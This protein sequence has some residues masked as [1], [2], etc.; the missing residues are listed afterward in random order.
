MRYA[1]TNL[2]TEDTL[3]SVS[4]EDTTFVK[5]YLYN[6]RQSLPMRFTA[7]VDNWIKIDL[8]SATLVEIVALL[9]HNLPS[10]ATV[11]IRANATDRGTLANW[12]SS[13]SYSS[14]MTFHKV[15]MCKEISE[16]YRWWH[17]EIDG[18]S[19]DANSELGEFFLGTTESFTMNYKWPFKEGTLRTVN[20]NLS[21]HGQRW[22]TTIAKK[23][24]FSLDFD[25]ITDA[26]LVAEIEAF[27]EGHEM[28][29]PFVFVPV[30]GD[31]ECYFVFCIND[32]QAARNFA[33]L[34]ACT[35]ELEE[36][37]RGVSII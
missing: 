23:K 32:E 35:L 36:Q 29:S 16:T 22:R 14:T 28:D 33:D 15:S 17:I 3:D 7:K 4:T 12:Q 37:T 27:F 1:A 10:N 13:S 31:S 25:A 11:T 20:E 21:V 18:A 2:L 19:G 6:A 5:E 26:N 30:S 9:N 34:N 8:G 24:S